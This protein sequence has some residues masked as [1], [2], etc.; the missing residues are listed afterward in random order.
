MRL[1]TIKIVM[2]AATILYGI[3]LLFVAR[4]WA[5]DMLPLGWI[6][7]AFFYI[8]EVVFVWML[9]RYE[10]MK[11][12]SVIS[13]SMLLRGVKFLGVAAMMLVWVVV[14]LPAKSPFLLYTLG[15]YLLTSLFEGWSVSVYNKEKKEREKGE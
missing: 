5:P 2:E 10:K 3:A 4:K 14:G 15:F 6:S 12:Q 8:Y 7:P 11:P 13:V 1:R 9:G